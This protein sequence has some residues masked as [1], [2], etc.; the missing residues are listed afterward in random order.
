[1]AE[2]EPKCV[3]CGSK[4]GKIIFFVEKT[5]KKSKEFL[6]IRKKF[7]LKYGNSE[8]PENVN[9]TD[10]YHREC[11][12]SFTALLPRYRNSSADEAINIKKKKLKAESVCFY[13]EKNQQ[14]A[15]DRQQI[16]H[17]S[18]NAKIYEKIIEWMT[19]LKNDK[20][21]KKI[22]CL[23]SV[24]GTVFYHHFYCNSL[25]DDDLIKLEEIDII[26][27]AALILRKTILEINSECLIPEKLDEFF[28]VLIGDKDFYRKDINLDNLSNSMASDLIFCVSNGA[29]IPTNHVTL[30]KTI[31]NFSNSREI[32]DTLNKLGHCCDYE[33]LEKFETEAIVSSVQSSRVNSSD[34][35]NKEERLMDAEE[36]DRDIII[37]RDSWDELN[38]KNIIV[39]SENFNESP[40]LKKRRIS[41]DIVVLD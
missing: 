33:T 4:E 8:L 40:L 35:P 3:F 30:G 26:D 23:K 37:D 34:T 13:C 18:N 1:M 15:D 39:E 21:L 6:P 20:L 14:S 12:S 5:L 29:V 2:K 27:K 10:G 11:Y 25:E 16:Y 28:K 17:S 32:I 31:K 24:S 22:N 36:I 38:G 19:I 7:N 9:T 41:E